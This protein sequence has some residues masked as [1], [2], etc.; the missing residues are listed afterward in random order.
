MHRSTLELEAVV[1]RSVCPLV[2]L[3]LT[4]DASGFLRNVQILPGA[5]QWATPK[6]QDAKNDY[7]GEH[8]SHPAADA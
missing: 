6:A 3:Q 5:G 4:L 2:T 8:L 1:M 7:C